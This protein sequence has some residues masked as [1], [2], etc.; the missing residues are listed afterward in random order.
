MKKRYFMKEQIEIEFKLLIDQT[1][2]RSIL[3]DQKDH[4]YASYQQTNYYL[5]HPLLDSLHYMLRIRQKQDYYE[6]TLKRPNAIGNYELNI[7]LD[8]ET[9]KRI[10]QKQP[11]DNEIFS[12]LK[13]HHIDIKELDMSHFLITTRH[14][15]KTD[16]GII[17]IDKNEYHGIVDYELEYEVYDPIKGKKAFLEFIS[18]YHLT[19]QT[20]C[21]SKIKR[22]KQSI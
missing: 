17:S 11:V 7:V 14:D 5:M 3:E 8:K 6:L 10:F 22:M 2:Y 13:K 19:Y 9:V 16:H 1:T 21:F 20:N 4:I 12:L 15:I 18:K